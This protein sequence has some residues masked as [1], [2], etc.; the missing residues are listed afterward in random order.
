MRAAVIRSASSSSR[1]E[2]DPY[3]CFRSLDSMKMR[4]GPVVCALIVCGW[5]QECF[6]SQCALDRAQNFQLLLQ[7]YLAKVFRTKFYDPLT[8]MLLLLTVSDRLFEPW[9]LQDSP[10]SDL[11][12]FLHELAVEISCCAQYFIEPNFLLAHFTKIR[13]SDRTLSTEL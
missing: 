3:Y 13:Q 2:G 8:S 5:F 9:I 7:F 12:C 11:R 6:D 1:D 10:R 4:S